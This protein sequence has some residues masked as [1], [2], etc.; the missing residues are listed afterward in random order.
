MPKCFD[1]MREHAKVLSRA[2]KIFATFD[3]YAT[4]KG[5]VF[6]EF[7][8]TPFMGGYFRPTA[9]RLFVKY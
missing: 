4:P 2:Y 8:P 9:Q 3:F 5:A 1:Y 6:G 7:T